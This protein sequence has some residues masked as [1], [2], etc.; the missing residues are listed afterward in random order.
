MQIRTRVSEMLGIDYPIIGAPM[1]LVSY[2]DL[3]CAVSNAGGIG[4]MPA[5]NYRTT[6]ELR[7]GLAEMRART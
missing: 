4:S 1:F 3:V 7:S 6:D 2:P 5:L